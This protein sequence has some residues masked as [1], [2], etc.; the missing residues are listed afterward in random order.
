[1]DTTLVPGISWVEDPTYDDW[2][3]ERLAGVQSS[4]D[5]LTQRVRHC[6][7]KQGCSLYNLYEGETRVGFCVVRGNMTDEGKVLHIWVLYH[8]GE[9]DPMEAHSEF[10]DDMARSIGAG[11]ITFTSNR[12]G[13]LRKAPKYGFKLKELLFQRE[14]I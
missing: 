10:F 3:W 12:V 1:M 9:V 7:A 13:W 4:E 2:F 5:N 6:F 8:E 14:V 11:R